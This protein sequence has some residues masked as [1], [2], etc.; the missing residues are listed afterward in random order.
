MKFAV[1]VAFTLSIVALGCGSAGGSG[2]GVQTI[3]PAEASTLLERDSSYV[4]LDVRTRA[5]YSGETGHLR[6]ALLVPVDSLDSRL[7]ELTPYRTKTIVTYCR[8]GPR[9]VRAEKFLLQHGFRVVSIAGGITRW[10]NE[11]LPVVK[12]QP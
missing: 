5:E 9:S 10:N 7:Q 4:F 6:G 11:H 2:A 1:W 8:T 3:A 12:E